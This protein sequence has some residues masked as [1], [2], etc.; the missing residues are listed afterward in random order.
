MDKTKST[1]GV[2]IQSFFNERLIRQMNASENT[3]RSY[4]DNL[5]L[6]LSYISQETNRNINKITID[7]VTAETILNFLDYCEETRGCS[8]RSR[9]QRL[10][11]LKSFFKHAVFTDPTLL[12]QGERIFLIP[13]KS[14]ERKVIGYLT[15]EEVEAIL[16]VPNRETM[17]GRRHYAILQLMYNTGARATEITKLN[18]FDLKI[19]LGA[20]QV[21]INGKGSKQRVVPIWNETANILLD[22][23]SEQTENINSITPIFQNQ[24]GERITRNG[25]RYVVES[26]VKT[27]EK[28]CQSLIGRNISPHT[29]RHTTAMH[30]LQSGVD[31]NLIRM[32]LGHVKMDTTH[33][34]I[35]SDTEMKRSALM[36]GGLISPT[37][38]PKWNPTPEIL[39][40][41]DSIGK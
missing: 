14:Y 33:Q 2:L 35:E 13:T 27:A 10:A 21:L 3:L 36:R 32:W 22:L 31:I 15:K 5:R 34:Y 38:T 37:E 41:L 1:L 17:T 4:R 25:I 6:F 20:S 12:A 23:I 30:L 26:S 24:G 9:N 11:S 7:D 40:F 18:T 39:A 28:N 8:V 29:F 16:N 19:N